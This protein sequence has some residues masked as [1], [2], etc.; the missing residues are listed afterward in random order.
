MFKRDLAHN[1]RYYTWY[2][3]LAGCIFTLPIWVA[4]YTQVITLP[5]LAI[6]NAFEN[7]FSITLEVPTGALADLIGR[8]TT[9]FLGKL[10]EA[11]MFIS[12]PF[13]ADF[14]QILLLTFIGSIG[15]ALVSGSDSAIL[16]DTLKEQGREV[17]FGKIYSKLLIHYR[18]GL[19]ICSFA[20]GLLFTVWRGLPY[21][22]RGLFYIAS[23]FAA[24]LLVEPKLDSKKFTWSKYLTQTKQ[25]L[26]EITRSPFVRKLAAYYIVVAGITY[27]CIAYFNLP[28]AYDFGFTPSQMGYIVAAAYIVSSL[29][30]HWLVTKDGLLTR[31]RV[32]LGFPLLLTIALLPGIFVGRWLA[33]VLMTLSQ[34]AGSGRFT[35][36]DN[37]VNQEFSSQNRATALSTL[38]MGVSLCMALLIFAGGRI[39]GIF[40]T[41]HAY[42]FLGILTL[43]I[44][45]PLAILL[46]REHH[47]YHAAQA[48]IRPH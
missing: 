43:F 27:A 37:Y 16:Y 17:E 24:F 26:V 28:F 5:Q 21:L 6:I 2:Y 22:T 15:A 20:G 18:A 46:V 36:L 14:W 47:R 39:Q 29:I 13:A 10:L 33:L 1:L 19:I 9:I 23:G 30:I 7:I 4:F 12:M 11:A 32:Y 38:N 48:I 41:R 8:R 45:T 25:G 34:V 40:D 44:V 3:T 31:T 42:T 35:I